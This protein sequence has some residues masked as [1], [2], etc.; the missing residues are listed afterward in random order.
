MNNNLQEKSTGEDQDFGKYIERIIA[1]AKEKKD[2]ANH[3]LGVPSAVAER[4]ERHL[5]EAGSIA[6]PFRH[7]PD[8]KAEAVTATPKVE[9]KSTDSEAVE[10]AEKP[11]EA[12]AQPDGLVEIAEID[13]N[14]QVKPIEPV[15]NEIKSFEPKVE[16][17]PPTQEAE[18]PYK[19]QDN[20]E[21]A[22]AVV[23]G[24]TV[25]PIV[26]SAAPEISMPQ[27]E[28][29]DGESS[30]IEDKKLAEPPNKPE[31]PKEPEYPKPVVI[32]ENV[33]K[34]KE[35]EVENVLGQQS[36]GPNSKAFHDSEP[37]VREEPTGTEAP[38]EVDKSATVQ[39]DGVQPNGHYLQGP[40]A[41]VSEQDGSDRIKAIKR[42]INGQTG[43]EIHQTPVGQAEPVRQ[44]KAETDQISAGQTAE[45]E[46]PEATADEGVHQLIVK[47]PS[48]GSFHRAIEI[49]K[50]PNITAT[51]LSSLR[52]G[53]NIAEQAESE[54]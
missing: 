44:P 14:G 9:A 31:L 4:R 47:Q 48:N 38:I 6:P 12:A 53:R 20:K 3:H 29:P 22:K 41:E 26:T 24:Q 7:F 1:K 15:T 28:I 46:Q 49:G 32:I 17:E 42:N 35:A 37:P 34:A 39:P 25:P 45:T 33:I 8:T 19:G 50:R 27:A 23:A 13:A 30:T 43:G 11:Q 16:K 21:R 51:D 52:P 54:E 2:G 10:T 36:D 40:K 18:A 5:A